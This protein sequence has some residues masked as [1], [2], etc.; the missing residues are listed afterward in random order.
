[1]MHYSIEPRDQIF[2]K[3][4]E[5]LLFAKHMSKDVSRNLQRLLDHA[6]PS[7]TDAL[8]PASDRKINKTVETTGYLIGNNIADKITKFLRSLPHNDLEAIESETEIIGFNKKIP[9]ERYTSPEKRQQSIN[10]LR[11]I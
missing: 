11:S 3:V 2:L 9:K 10:Y 8:K 7:V 4:Y 1:M 6:K 5:F